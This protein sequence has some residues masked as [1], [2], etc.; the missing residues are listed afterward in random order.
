MSKV[1]KNG[2]ELG[3]VLFENKIHCNEGLKMYGKEYELFLR[4]NISDE[5]SVIK[6]FIRRMIIA[7]KK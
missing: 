3:K 7:F 5:R 1:S 4:V 2:I 6:E